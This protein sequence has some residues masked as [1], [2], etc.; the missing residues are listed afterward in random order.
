MNDLERDI[1]EIRDDIKRMEDLMEENH[2]M[3]KRL[4]NAYRFNLLFSI[5]RWAIIIGL[6]FGLFYY[7]QPYLEKLLQLYSSI[8]SITGGVE[9]NGGIDILKALK[10]F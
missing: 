9:N 8:N 3:I 5:I 2:L 10:T 6:T 1:Q 7:T 4:H